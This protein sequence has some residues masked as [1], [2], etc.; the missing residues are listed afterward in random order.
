MRMPHLDNTGSMLNVEL[1]NA[2][3]GNGKVARAGLAA[4]GLAAS[5]DGEM[6]ELAQLQ[7]Y[8][9][10]L[11][12]KL[13]EK[14]VQLCET[15]ESLGLV[16]ADFQTFALAASHDLQAPLRSITGFSQYLKEEYESNLD[17]LANDYINRIVA[18][19]SK[20]KSQ[21]A[22][23]SNFAKV[24]SQAAPFSAVCL[25]SV[26]ETAV[27]KH[28]HRIKELGIAVDA[29]PLPIIFGDRVQLETL[30]ANLIDNCIKFRGAEPTK[31]TVSAKKTEK[32]WVVAIEDNGIGIPL[33]QLDCV[34]KI[35]RHLD[36]EQSHRG[37]GLTVCR[38][39]AERHTGRIYFCSQKRNGCKCI[40]ELPAWSPP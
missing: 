35:F 15:Q 1:E 32:K 7:Q 2:A 28:E 26:W 13:S 33:D 30:F 5:Y 17:E 14:H 22:G 21:L 39:I 36:S 23:L 34:F 40:V 12:K 19:S 4:S 20:M 18:S 31:V 3:G 9:E 38:R 37:V 8:C 25:N 11:E 27:V 16:Q 10:M 29:A 6:Q 24:S